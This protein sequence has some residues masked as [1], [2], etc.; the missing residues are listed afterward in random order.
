MRQEFFNPATQ[1]G[2]I[3]ETFADGTTVVEIYDFSRPV[4]VTLTSVPGMDE[5]RIVKEQTFRAGLG[6]VAMHYAR[7]FILDRD[8]L[9]DETI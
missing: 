8:F 9:T 1:L 6:E 5:Y 4:S 2:S 7:V 3:I